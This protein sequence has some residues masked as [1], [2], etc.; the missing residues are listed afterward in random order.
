MTF[1]YLFTFYFSGWIYPG[2]ISNVAVDLI[3]P[4]NA[5]PDTANTVTLYIPGTEIKEKS[6]YLYVQGS[7]SKVMVKNAH[8]ISNTLLKTNQ[9][10]HQKMKF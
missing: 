5:A 2:Q 9:Q 4:D 8:L 1:Y 10:K 6:A 7:L 3:I